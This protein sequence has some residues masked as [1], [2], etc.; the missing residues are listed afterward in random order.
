M[1]KVTEMDMEK[2]KAAQAHSDAFCLGASVL[3]SFFSIMITFGLA[4]SPL[5]PPHSW[6]SLSL[7]LA[8]VSWILLVL[9]SFTVFEDAPASLRRSIPMQILTFIAIISTASSV[10][11]LLSDNKIGL[12]CAFFLFTVLFS[13]FVFECFW[14][15]ISPGSALSSVKL[16]DKAEK[17]AKKQENSEDAP[18]NYSALLSRIYLIVSGLWSSK[19]GKTACF[20]LTA[21]ATDFVFGYRLHDFLN[22]I[23]PALAVCLAI[24]GARSK[25]KI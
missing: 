12:L 21:W 10:G 4:A 15:Y 23:I 24:Y 3:F 1:E 2:K 17:A 13:F 5:N 16:K 25:L 18:E 7:Q 11:Y 20:A 19:S 8:F 6:L 14:F 22:Y 9:L